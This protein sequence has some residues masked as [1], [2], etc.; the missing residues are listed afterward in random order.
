MNDL[1]AQQLILLALF[2]SFVTSIATGIFTVSLLEQAPATVTQTINRVVERTIETVIEGKTEVVT[3]LTEVPAEERITDAIKK[4]SPSLVRIVVASEVAVA[5]T[6]ATASLAGT[7]AVGTHEYIGFV[8]DADFGII[9]TDSALVGTALESIEVL[10]LDGSRL[11]VLD[12]YTSVDVPG[13]ALVRST[14]ST[15]E[16]VSVSLGDERLS[17]GQTV[18]TLGYD[19]AITTTSIG[20][21]S[22]YKAQTA[23]SSVVINTN[24]NPSLHMVGGPLLISDG[25]VVGLQAAK[26]VIVPAEHITT[27]LQEYRLLIRQNE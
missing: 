26:E 8:V 14:H 5:T 9:A 25:T 17:L 21:I 12:V 23:S 19:G 18:I 13:L 4:V 27:L 11:K 22:G 3:T 24:I 15:G 7:P 20:F 10:L 1:N 16:L 2:V 6:S